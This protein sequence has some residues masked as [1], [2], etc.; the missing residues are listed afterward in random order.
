[1]LRYFK[2]ML[3]GKNGRIMRMALL[4]ECVYQQIKWT[5]VGNI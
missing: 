3:L 4:T 1:M 5:P 2:V